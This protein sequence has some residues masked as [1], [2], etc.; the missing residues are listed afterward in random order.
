MFETAAAA[1]KAKDAAVTEAFSRRMVAAYTAN[2]PKAGGVVLNE[3]FTRADETCRGFTQSARLVAFIDM[4][5]SR[6]K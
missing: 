4:V 5:L 2:D 1:R 6:L 3:W